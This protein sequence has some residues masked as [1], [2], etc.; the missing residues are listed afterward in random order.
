MIKSISGNAENKS[1]Y[2][3]S[4]PL[5][6]RHLLEFIA[7]NTVILIE[8]LGISIFTPR[9]VFWNSKNVLFGRDLVMILLFLWSL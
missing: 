8:S 3:Y 5:G 2:S 4:S 1:E 7:I 6:K 9:S